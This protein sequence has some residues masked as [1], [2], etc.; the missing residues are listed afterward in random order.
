MRM[1][2]DLEGK[3]DSGVMTNII[4][5]LIHCH[6]YLQSQQG[7]NVREMGMEF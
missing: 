4:C 3:P 6:L 1:M 5:G 2:T 7:G